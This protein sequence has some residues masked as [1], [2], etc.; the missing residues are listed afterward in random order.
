MVNIVSCWAH[1]AK[2]KGECARCSLF[3]LRKIHWKTQSIRYEGGTEKWCAAPGIIEIQNMEMGDSNW[4][5]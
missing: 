2:L 3:V 5:H 1:N 4:N